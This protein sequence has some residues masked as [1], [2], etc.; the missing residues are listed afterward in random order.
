MMAISPQARLNIGCGRRIVAGA[1]NLDVSEGLGADIVHDLNCLPW[2]FADDT[3]DEVHAYDVLEHLQD[4]PRTLEEIHRVCRH[5]ASVHMTVPHFSCANA[6]TDVTHCHWFGSR[7][8]DPFIDSRGDTHELAHYARARFRCSST[9]IHFHPS[10]V[11]K[12]IW[13]CANRWPHAYEHRWAW[14]FPAWFMS[15]RLE[16]VKHAR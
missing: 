11:N 15:I 6:F 13:R 12:L 16:V 4:V 2:P 5:G 1:V 10:L 8:F 9:Q 3:F 7:S 14:M